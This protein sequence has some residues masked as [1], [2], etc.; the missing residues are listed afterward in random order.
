MKVTIKDVAR[1]AKVAPSTVS[2]VLSDSP[3]ISEETKIK[4]NKA[5]EKLNYKP[6]AIAR[7]LVSNKTKI[8]GVVLP[9]EANDL[10]KNPF[11]VEAMR[12]MSMAAEESGYYI[13][14]AFSK[15]D[16][17]E[18]KIIKEFANNNLLEGLCLLSVREDDRTIKYLKDIKFPFVV[19]GRPDEE[20]ILWV[21]NDNFKAMFKL[22][23]KFI[24]AGEIDLAFIG[25]KRNWNVSKDRLNG[26]KDAFKAN[27]LN[28][29]KTMVT[30]GKDFSE[31]CGYLAMKEL[32]SKRTPKVVVTTDDLLALGANKFLN[33]KRI[34][35]VKIVGFNNT[36]MTKYQNPPISSIDINAIELG[37]EA[38]KLLIDYLN[39]NLSNR[40]DYCIVDTEF[41]DRG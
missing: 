34:E 18:L 23:N 25:G 36:P 30:E 39:N 27:N 31:E 7:S 17:D 41:I 26:F 19:I 32:I 8:L 1:E 14:Y 38:T 13:M 33:E 2:R 37:Y 11:F 15:N 5:I 35:G 20:G 21:D 3:K 28:Y 4:V 10:F 29:D 9:N 40:K 24:K 12:G 22:V 6:N 16:D